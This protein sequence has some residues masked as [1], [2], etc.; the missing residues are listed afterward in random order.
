MSKEGCL[1]R[2][3]KYKR[4]GNVEFQKAEE[5]FCEENYGKVEET[6]SKK[7]KK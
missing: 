7:E 6:V 4:L 3:A 5:K 2:I 1:S